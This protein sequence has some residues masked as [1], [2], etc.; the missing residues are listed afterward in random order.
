[1]TVTRSGLMAIW[2]ALLGLLAGASLAAQGV[3]PG[4]AS[5]NL[6]PL[7]REILKELIE[8]NTTLSSGSTTLASER[9]AARLLAVGLARS[10]RW[11]PPVRATMATVSV[12]VAAASVIA[13]A[14]GAFGLSRPRAPVFVLGPPIT[15]AVA[16]VAVIIAALG[17]RR[18]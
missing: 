9:M 10:P 17:A 6:M 14:V 2:M 12:I 8:T 11:P 15:S 3:L 18:R 4:T 7:S 13:Y 16:V 5:P 1:M